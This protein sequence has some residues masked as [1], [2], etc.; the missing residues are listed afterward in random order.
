[1]VSSKYK[2]VIIITVALIVILTVGYIIK[3]FVSH[4][5]AP[6]TPTGEIIL[7]VEG[8]ILKTNSDNAFTFDLDTLRSLGTITYKEYDPW[9]KKELEYTGVPLVKVLKYVGVS[10]GAT[11]VIVIAKDKYKV[12]FNLKALMESEVGRR[13][14]LTFIV[15]GKLLRPVFKFEVD[16]GGPIR[17]AYPYLKGQEEVIKEI[18]ENLLVGIWNGK[19]RVLGRKFAL[20]HEWMVCKIIIE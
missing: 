20:A 8:K 13:I 17:L 16:A 9:F 12:V 4:I 19:G 1:M 7:R 14:L 3:S 11:K 6:T 18:E 15:N 10:N 2:I 5:E